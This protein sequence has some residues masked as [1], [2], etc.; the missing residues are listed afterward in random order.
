[1][2]ILDAIFEMIPAD[3]GAVVLG[4]GAKDFSSVYGKHR[5]QSS[6][7]V[8]ISRTV[9]EH[10]MRERLAV[11]TNDIKTSETL[12]SADSL[13]AAQITSLMCVPLI[14]V[15]KMLGAIYLDTSDP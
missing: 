4:R 13:V 6:Y 5:D 1:R 3:R 7:P 2:E 12:K 11:L 9:V 10:V 14:V 8:N 15:D